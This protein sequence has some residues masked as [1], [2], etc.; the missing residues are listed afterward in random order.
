MGGN[1]HDMIENEKQAVNL[2]NKVY[3]KNVHDRETLINNLMQET[4]L[5]K[6][7]DISNLFNIFSMRKSLFCFPKISRVLS[8][9]VKVGRDF[10]FHCAS[11]NLDIVNLI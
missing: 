4:S 6:L 9:N 10:T 7:P 3:T 2:Q 8:R 1:L 5:R 11:P